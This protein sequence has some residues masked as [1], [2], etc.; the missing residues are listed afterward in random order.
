MGGEFIVRIG[1]IKAVLQIVVGIGKD[2]ILGGIGPN[3]VVADGG[4]VEE[5]STVRPGD[6]VWPAVVIQVDQEAGL[7]CGDILA[8]LNSIGYLG[9]SGNMTWLP[10]ES[11]GVPVAGI[12]QS[13]FLGGVGRSDGGVF[14]GGGTGVIVEVG[15]ADIVVRS[16]GGIVRQGDPSGFKLVTAGSICGVAL[17]DEIDCSIVVYIQG[18]GNRRM[19]GDGSGGF[20]AVV[21]DVRVLGVGDD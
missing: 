9:G 7:A 19:T 5:K 21:V 15:E 16:P 10:G 12:I 3:L 17:T 11:F 14:P 2:V 1:L 8:G 18:D 13:K 20:A 4:G 6:G